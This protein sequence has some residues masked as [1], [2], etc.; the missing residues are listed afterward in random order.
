[1][2]RWLSNVLHL[3]LKEFA[4]LMRD[5]V[6]LAFIVYSFSI[7]I[8]S[9]ATGVKIEVSNAA[10]AIVDGDRSQLSRRIQD[11]L[12]KP[13]FKPAMIID[14]S[15]VDTLMDRGKVSFVL[16]IPP[17]FEADILAGR[18]PRLQ[19]SI[20]ATAMTQAGVGASYIEEIVLDVT[21]AWLNERGIEAQLPVRPV[22]RAFFNPNLESIRFQAVMALVENITMISILLVG[23]A[24]IRE[25]EHG[26][27][28]HLLVMPVGSSEIAA[29]KIWASGV[30]VLVAVALS[31]LIVINRILGVPIKGSLT[32]FL[33]GTATYLFA[34]AALGI[35]LATDRQHDAAVR[36]AV[37]AG[38]PDP[39]HVVR[40]HLAAREHADVHAGGSAS[41]PQR[42]LRQGDA[43]RALPRRRSG[44]HLAAPP[45]PVRPRRAVPGC[46]SVALPRHARP[47]RMRCDSGSEPPQA[48]V[49]C[50]SRSPTW[51]TVGSPGSTAMLKPNSRHIFSMVKF[52]ASTEPESSRRP[53][54]LA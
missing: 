14:R 44:D 25:R 16:D 6:L 30:V 2:R 49:I 19:L 46:R 26:T 27:I 50:S 3:G 17:R 47:A 45:R 37:D 24:V 39:D 18:S 7:M 5:R 21:L 10:I 32:L 36:A 1:M 54:A 33:V 8:Y 43:R 29:A 38:V 9:D 53:V 13:H 15:E 20:D 11:A 12:L 48:E 22:V 4:S 40:L 34:L 52:S 51:R 35:L 28:E 41:L 23:A 31:L 42:A